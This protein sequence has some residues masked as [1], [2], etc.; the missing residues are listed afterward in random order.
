[1]EGKLYK[2]ENGW[3]IMRIEEGDWETYY[4]IHHQHNLWLKVFGE[5]GSKMKFKKEENFAILIELIDSKK[6]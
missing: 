1:M 2:E 4:P 3:S 5:E 6:I